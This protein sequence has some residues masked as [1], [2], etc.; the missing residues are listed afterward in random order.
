MDILP[1]PHPV[2]LLVSLQRLLTD[3]S[4]SLG[5][6]LEAVC[7]QLGVGLEVDSVRIDRIGDGT[8]RVETLGTWSNGAVGA[9]PSCSADLDSQARLHAYSDGVAGSNVL[10]SVPLIRDSNL[11]GFIHVAQSGL[12]DAWTE[13]QSRLLHQ[14]ASL[15]A[16]KIPDEP[17]AEDRTHTNTGRPPRPQD[18]ADGKPIILVVEDD[19]SN[20]HVLR[21][22]I[23]RRGA[24]VETAQ[25]GQEAV[26]ACIRTKFD[27]IMMDLRMPDLDGFDATRE[28]VTGRNLNYDTPI[29]AVTADTTEGIERRC[30]KLGMRHYI[31]KPIRASVI[32][33]VIGEFTQARL[34]RPD[35]GGGR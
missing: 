34:H 18:G 11:I 24:L 2:S 29:I 28:I 17:T 33:D 9:L 27:I 20:A 13:A 25:S 16:G 8:R 3:E 7:E 22:I 23:E 6:R 1:H 32:S 4:S 14:A 21:K 35:E 15:I 12:S 26:A 5:A 31:S 19:P 10:E 30:T